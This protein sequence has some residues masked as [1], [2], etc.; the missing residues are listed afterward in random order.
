MNML[1]F[2]V[3]CDAVSLSNKPRSMPFAGEFK[4]FNSSNG[5]KRLSNLF[6]C[7]V[8]VED[9]CY[10]DN[11]PIT[12]TF[13]SVEALYVAAKMFKGDPSAVEHFKCG[14]MFSQWDLFAEK[15]AKVRMT[16]KQRKSPNLG[17]WSKINMIG[18]MSKWIG[19]STNVIAARFRET[20]NIRKPIKEV[21]D[22][23]ADY[24]LW[25]RLHTAKFA[26]TILAEVLKS[27]HPFRL[28]EFSRSAERVAMALNQRPEYWGGMVKDGVLYGENKM[29][30][31]ME[32]QR[33]LLRCSD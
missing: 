8:T 18:I 33:D 16:D 12:G 29:G 22:E 21:F 2:N 32:K 30:K 26:D 23:D 7:K 14:G 19:S 9:F 15:F 17:Y 4:Y 6:E 1:K 27:T 20:H 11:P 31:L 5:E 3:S 13:N 28:V 25:E 24:C 10:K